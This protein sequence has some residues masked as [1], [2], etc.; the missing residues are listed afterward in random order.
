M[1]KITDIFDFA[2]G[3]SLDLNKMNICDSNDSI[4]FVSRTGKNLGVSARVK[5]ID[6]ITAFPAGAITVALGGSILSS[7]IQPVPFYTAQNIA[8]LIPKKEMSFQEKVFYCMCIERNKFRYSTF[9]REANRTLKIL[10]IPSSIPAW[11]NEKDFSEELI[12]KY[13]SSF[14]DV[15]S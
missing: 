2:Y 9:G 15:F 11:V 10:E 6:K 3:N 5:K 14:R 8:V 1:A 12:N 4:N 13:M 7:F